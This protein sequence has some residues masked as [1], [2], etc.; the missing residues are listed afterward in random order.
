VSVADAKL[1]STVTSTAP[2]GTVSVVSGIQDGYRLPSVPEFTFNASATYHWEM[3]SGWLGYT[4][5][6]YQHI[7][8]RYTQVGDQSPGTGTVNLLALPNTLGG[9]LTQTTFTFNPLLPAYDI[10][11]LRLG[12]LKG[13]W[14]L[15][16][17]GNNLTD[18]RALLALDRER[19]ELA[20]VGY[21]TNQP[22]TF[23][24]SARVLF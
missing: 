16:L 15:A 2:D 14:D 12:V 17:Y 13:R 3:G 7:G 8:S 11:N 18:E 22:R 19:G 1:K 20:R 21:L 23:G 5:G 24:L 6:T 4:T 9:P 10:V